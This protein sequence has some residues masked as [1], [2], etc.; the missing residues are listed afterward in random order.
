MVTLRVKRGVP[1][2]RSRSFV[3][4]FKRS[5][6]AVR[7]RGDFRIVHYS[8]Q[9]NHVHLIV[10]SAGK[11]ALG[12]GMRSV[13]QRLARVVH[14][15]YGRRGPVLDGR[16]HLRVL[17]TPREVRAAI[18]YVLLNVRRHWSQRRGKPP[19]TKLD[20]AS[21]GRWFT[22]WK[23]P[24]PGS[25]RDSAARCEVSPAHTWLLAKGWRR[26]GLVNPAEVPGR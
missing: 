9:A 3:R 17:K 4:D 10:E 20:E 19:A 22:G 7:A 14:R 18:A 23:W 5:L 21:S 12:C 2:L 1:S 6:R 11:R 24:P 26:H 25:R 15:V 13:G 8:L 16:Y